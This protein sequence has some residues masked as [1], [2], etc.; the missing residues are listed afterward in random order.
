MLKV[1]YIN[2]NMNSAFLMQMLFLLQL[3]VRH[4]TTGSLAVKICRQTNQVQIVHGKVCNLYFLVSLNFI[5][6][7]NLTVLLLVL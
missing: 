6:C 7:M 1:W 4:S 5:G 3:F 2:V